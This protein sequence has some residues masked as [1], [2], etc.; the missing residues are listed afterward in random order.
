MEIARPDGAKVAIAVRTLV[1][2]RYFLDGAVR[3][4][5]YVALRFHCYG[6]FTHCAK[7]TFAVCE[8][9][10]AEP[11]S[12]A[13]RKEAEETHSSLVV[14]DGGSVQ[15]ATSVDWDEFLSQLGGPVE[16][17]LP[18]HPDF[19]GQLLKLAIN[20]LPDGL[21]GTANEQFEDY[22]YAALQF[23][24][25]AR[26][27]RYGQERRF[28]K[29]PD[30]IAFGQDQPFILYDAKAYARGYPVKPDS[31]RQFADYVADFNRRY[32]RYIGRVHSFVVI[33]GDFIGNLENRSRELYEQCQVPMSYLRADDL[34]GIVLQFAANPRYR[35]S[36]NWYKILSQLHVT[37]QFV[38][39]EIEKAR[40]DKI[41][42][43]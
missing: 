2:N 3:H 25:P 7:Y 36:V 43:G 24:L 35:C 8:R 22:V 11:E 9:E 29:V 18:R 21:I 33:S 37:T 41:L 13:L 16:S 10:L 34:A 14:V 42:E 4:P 15:N 12:K 27:V 40:R 1:A 28:E 38:G 39:L 6:Q 31:V 30:G 26:V 5:A 32:R 23:V 19:A 17:D 20:Q